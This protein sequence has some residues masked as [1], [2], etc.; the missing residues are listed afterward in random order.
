MVKLEMRVY[1]GGGIGF[2]CKHMAR[3]IIDAL[4]TS[5]KDLAMHR[6]QQF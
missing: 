1:F 6:F 3:V 2:N 5:L 4:I